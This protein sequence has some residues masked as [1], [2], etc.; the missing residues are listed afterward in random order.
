MPI[1]IYEFGELSDEAKSI[2][3]NTFR[4]INV[5]CN[6]H[7]T[8]CEDAEV[9]GLKITEFDI[10]RN[11]IKGHLKQD[12]LD[13]CRLIR[14]NHG[15]DTETRDTAKKYL[16]EYI[17]EYYR[18]RG[19][20]TQ[21]LPDLLKGFQC[22]DEAKDIEIDFALAL[23]EDY[24]IMLRREYEYLTSDEAVK[25]SIELNEMKFLENGNVT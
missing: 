5:D 25:E 2:A 18:Y 23:L 8:V 21:N 16:K 11:T 12:F 24:F 14:K 1:T 7:E 22:E 9:I 17:A 19:N 15:K 10:D 6:W 13:V 3:L 4:Y 20:D